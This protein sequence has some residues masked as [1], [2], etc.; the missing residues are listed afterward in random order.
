MNDEDPGFQRL[1]TVVFFFST[2]ITRRKY[3]VRVRN[4][5]GSLCQGWGFFDC[6]IRDRWR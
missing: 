1:P 3:A 6:V 2:G 5:S 4:E